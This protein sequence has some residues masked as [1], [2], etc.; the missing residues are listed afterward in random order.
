MRR[1]GGWSYALGRLPVFAS[2]FSRSAFR[3]VQLLCL[4]V[5]GEFA[6]PCELSCF[7]GQGLEGVSMN[8][9]AGLPIADGRAWLEVARRPRSERRLPS[10]S[11]RGE[12]KGGQL[13]LMLQQSYSG[14][15][16][17]M[18]GDRDVDSTLVS[19]ISGRSSLAYEPSKI[20]FA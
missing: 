1:T 8:S 4:R 9:E 19:P 7:E 3:Q 18:V 17:W 11:S 10:G 12:V 16:G 13:P 15:E 14:C 20:L 6:L 2:G 5:V